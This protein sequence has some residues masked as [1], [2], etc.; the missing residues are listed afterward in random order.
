M[1]TEQMWFFGAIGSLIM[2]VLSLILN[3]VRAIKAV[4]I[5][6]ATAIEGLKVGLDNQ[7]KVTDKVPCINGKPCFMKG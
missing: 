7:Q 3:D 6:N 1:T 2:F 4:A 5:S